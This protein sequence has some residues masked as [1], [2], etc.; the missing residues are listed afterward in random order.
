MI[1]K[2]LLFLAKWMLKALTFL[3]KRVHYESYKKLL[4]E[5]LERFIQDLEKENQDV[6]NE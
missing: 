5:D 3:R 6:W 2:Q 1:D 4:E